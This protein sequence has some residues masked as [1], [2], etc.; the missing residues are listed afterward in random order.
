MTPRALLLLG[1]ALLASGCAARE[2]TTE[3]ATIDHSAGYRYAALEKIAPKALPDTFV[4]VTFSGGGTRAAALATGALQGLATATVPAAG[5]PVNFADQI[6]LI[7]S[8]SGGSVTAAYYGLYG[9][10]GLPLLTSNFLKRNVQGSLIAEALSPVTWVR[11]ATPSYAR[12]DALRDYLDDNVFDHATFQTM[13]DNA[14]KAQAASGAKERRPLVVLNGSDM[15]NGAVFSFT[16]DRFDLICSD[17]AKLKVADAVA[18]SAAFPVA[19]TALTLK[20]RAPC[21]AQ[22]AATTNQFSGWHLFDG[23][24]GKQHPRPTTL[25]NAMGDQEG[26]PGR[27]RRGLIQL[28]YLNETGQSPYI[29]LLD[30]GVSDNLGLTEPLYL[31]TSLDQYDSILRRQNRSDLK[32]VVFVVVNA[33]SEPDQTYG[34]SSTPPGAISTLL[35]TIGSPIDGTSFALQD[36]LGDILHDEIGP[37]VTTTQVRVDFDFIA[38]P[39]CRRTFKNLQTSWSL[40]RDQVDAL[41]QLGAAMVRESKQFQD[42]MGQLG[43]TI[44]TGPTTDQACQTLAA[45]GS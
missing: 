19:L 37:Q 42:L 18:A 21:A 11:L 24:D 15:A 22:T 41:E 4:V 45:V 1:L 12:I 3:L 2:R 28:G 27:Y 25:Q 33:R 32:H 10:Q 38:D 39:I 31:L 17:L 40:K 23:S 6:D 34:L 14:Q 43:G 36:R 9:R 16:Q 29:Q 7:S 20:N 5:A 26:N 8:V 35:T 13:L 44:G 30:G